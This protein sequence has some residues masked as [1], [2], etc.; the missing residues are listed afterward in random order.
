MGTDPALA[1]AVSG[2]VLFALAIFSCTCYRRRRTRNISKT[3]KDRSL[4]GQDIREWVAQRQAEIN[5]RKA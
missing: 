2:V 4:N 1:G 5:K 3:I